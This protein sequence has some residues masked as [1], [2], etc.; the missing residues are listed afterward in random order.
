MSSYQPNHTED[1]CDRCLAAV[2]KDSLRPLP[3]VFLDKNDTV[4][5]DKSPEMRD[6][7]MWLAVDDGYRQY[8][9]CPACLDE[10]NKITEGI[11]TLEKQKQLNIWKAKQDWKKVQEKKN[12]K[13]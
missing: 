9:V 5:A 10:Q 3:F 11:K 1:E 2:G 13:Q 8:Y 12:G 6:S 4:H 7:G